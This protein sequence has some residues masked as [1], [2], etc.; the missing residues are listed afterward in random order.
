M[1]SQQETG[2]RKNV[3]TKATA[4]EMSETCL[5]NLESP[6][7]NIYLFGY[8][9]GTLVVTKV[10]AGFFVSSESVSYPPGHEVALLS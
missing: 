6:L 3:R 1:T 5:V 10:L 7:K 8:L 2:Y 9:R 4:P